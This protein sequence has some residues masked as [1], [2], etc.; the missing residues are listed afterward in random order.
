MRRLGYRDSAPDDRLLER[1]GQL[2]QLNQALTAVA[3]AGRG[4]TA[5][6]MGE[7]GIG[8]TAL[9]RRFSS[10]VAGSARVLWATCDHLF[11]PRPLGPFL[12]LAGAAPG[13]L[14]ARMEG[15]ARPYDVAAALLAELGSGGTAMLVLEN[16]HWADEAS[17]DVIRLLFRR[18]ESVPVMLVLSYRDDELNRSHPLRLVLGDLSEGGHVTR[19]ELAGLSQSAVATLAGPQGLDATELCARTSGNPFFVTEVLAD[20]SGRIPQTVR[21]AVL[22]RAA[23]LGPAASE[24]LAAAAVVPGVAELWLLDQVAPAAAGSWTSALAP[25]SCSRATAGWRSGMRSRA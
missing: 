17:L 24:L 12:D 7:A 14:T 22:A 8:K 11:I 21:D 25:G 20:G 5:L 18:I 6:V 15:T 23:R 2:A 10:G 3:D 9:L 16:V 4:Q 13:Q 1:A 19:V